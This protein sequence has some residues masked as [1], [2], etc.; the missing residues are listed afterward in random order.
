MGAIVII[1]LLIIVIYLMRQRRSQ[2]R[3]PSYASSTNQRKSSTAGMSIGAVG[4]TSSI[5]NNDSLLEE[6]KAKARSASVAAR[7]KR[8]NY[9]QR[10]EEEDQE[11]KKGSLND[12][13]SD[14]D[15]MEDTMQIG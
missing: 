12:V 7:D 8:S 9:R 10:S 5:G 2:V 4:P 14:E 1:V 6:P 11:S 3:L 13:L 15:S